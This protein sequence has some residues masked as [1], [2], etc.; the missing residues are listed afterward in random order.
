MQGSLSEASIRLL[1][2]HINQ[3]IDEIVVPKLAG[4]SQ[5][6]E[7]QVVLLGRVGPSS[8]KQPDHLHLALD[9]CQLQRA[10]AVVI[11][12]VGGAAQQEHLRGPRD[13]SFRYHML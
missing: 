6:R 12:G 1:G 4:L 2:A 11:G 3:D 8:Q 5:G 10:P 13:V 9:A 7:A